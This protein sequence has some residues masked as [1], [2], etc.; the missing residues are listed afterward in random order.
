[1]GGIEDITLYT[2]PVVKCKACNTNTENTI[3]KVCDSCQSVL[4][5]LVQLVKTAKGRN[6]IED[7]LKSYS[8]EE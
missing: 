4:V 3:S 7:L 5:K 6:Y 2:M 1:M 8:I